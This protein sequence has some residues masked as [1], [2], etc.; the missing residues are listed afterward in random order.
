MR[1][2]KAGDR[3]EFVSSSDPYTKLTAG[4]LGTVTESRVLRFGYGDVVY[5]RWDDGSTLT[6]LRDEGDRFKVV[7]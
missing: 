7:T 4:T 1:K 3:I 5:V 6:M 2:V